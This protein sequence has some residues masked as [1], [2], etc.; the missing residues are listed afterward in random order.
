MCEREYDTVYFFVFVC[1]CVC[2]SLHQAGETVRQLLRVAKKTVPR[3]EWKRTP[4]VLRATA[5]LRLL[6]PKKAQALLDQVWEN[7]GWVLLDEEQEGTWGR[8]NQT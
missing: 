7:L 4:V 8:K 2:G 6:P 3:L 1:V 5:G